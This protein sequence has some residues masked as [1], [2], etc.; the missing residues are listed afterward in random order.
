MANLCC[1]A[2]VV[3]FGHSWRVLWLVYIAHE[4]IEVA[5]GLTVLV[6]NVEVPILKGISKAGSNA[7]CILPVGIVG[8]RAVVCAVRVDLAILIA[9][10]AVHCR[11]VVVAKANGKVLLGL[12]LKTK[13]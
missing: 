7:V 12:K 4:R 13:L 11:E 1:I 2:Y 9:I 6:G 5:I 8:C 10:L 3:V